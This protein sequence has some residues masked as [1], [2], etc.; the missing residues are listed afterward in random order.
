MI[1]EFD[2]PDPRLSPN[3]KNGAHYQSFQRAKYRAHSDAKILTLSELSGKPRIE[4]I[5]DTLTIK[6]IHPTRRNHDLDNSLASCKAHLDGF[7]AALGID[8]GCFSTI[9]LMKEYR[10]GIK[11]MVFEI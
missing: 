4:L 5:P 7:C 8:D 2:L 9:I 11:K 6:F 3:N 10:K 1:V